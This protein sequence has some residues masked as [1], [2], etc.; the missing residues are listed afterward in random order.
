MYD[1]TV[2]KTQL[3]EKLCE[4]RRQHRELFERAQV[5]FKARIIEELELRLEQARDGKPVNLMISLAQPID[6][7]EDYDRV[8]AML[9]MH[10]EEEVE[11]DERDFRCYVLD[12]WEWAAGAFTTNSAYVVS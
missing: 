12:K 7:T 3:I 8:I 10:T 2:K 9:E 11:L 5:G 1:I 4:N 6:Q